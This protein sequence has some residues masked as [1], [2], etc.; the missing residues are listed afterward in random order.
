MKKLTKE[1]NLQDI[2][3]SEKI[4]I[5]QFG[6][7]L[8]GPCFA[9]KHKIDIWNENHP[10]VKSIYVQAEDF[11]KVAA[12]FGVFTVPTILVFVEGKIT[13]R[14]IGYFSLEDILSKI[15]RYIEIMNL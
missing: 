6:S 14:E 2:I 5:V 11:R 3:N 13:I 4:L 7:Q 12:D 1:E 10:K 9:L 15:E 8:C